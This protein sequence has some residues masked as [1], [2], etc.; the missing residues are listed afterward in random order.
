M[1]TKACHFWCFVNL[2]GPSTTWDLALR[3]NKGPASHESQSPPPAPQVVAT[4]PPVGELPGVPGLEVGG[5]R[6]LIT[7]GIVVPYIDCA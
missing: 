7:F 3:G 1:N 4:L 5:E 2:V 6:G